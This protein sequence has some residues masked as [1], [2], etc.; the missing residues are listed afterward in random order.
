MDK[1]EAEELQLEAL[2]AK[3]KSLRT[4]ED[5]LSGW[6]DLTHRPLIRGGLG[7]IYEGVKFNDNE[8]REASSA[9]LLQSSKKL[10]DPLP[11][12]IIFTLGLW[13]GQTQKATIERQVEDLDG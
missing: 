1:E 7:A 2:G 3:V 5:I 9:V 10:E 13:L 8:V 12:L 6:H 4:I 11:I